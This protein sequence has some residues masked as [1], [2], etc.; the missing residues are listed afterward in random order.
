MGILNFFETKNKRPVIKD[1]EIVYTDGRVEDL[2]YGIS[3]IKDEAYYRRYDIESVIL[4]DSVAAIGISAFQTASNLESIVLSKN[5]SSIGYDAFSGCKSL[6]NIVIPKQVTL[7]PVHVFAYCE[8]LE[9]ITIP[10]SVTSIGRYAFSGCKA[11]R[12]I[13]YG[14]SQEEWKQIEIYIDGNQKLCGDKNEI[15]NIHFNCE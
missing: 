8:S 3:K 1:G 12:D 9:S 14:G 2:K 10:A 11:L 7:L 13:Y 5:L 4:P 6:K 15:A